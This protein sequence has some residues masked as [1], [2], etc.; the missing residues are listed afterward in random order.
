MSQI[1]ILGKI[2]VPQ[3]KA[4][5]LF[6]A[7]TLVTASI[8]LVLQKAYTIPHTD[9]ILLPKTG[10]RIGHN[11]PPTVFLTSFYR[12]GFSMVKVL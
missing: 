10:I 7:S 3:S 12:D 9:L 2:E 1:A 8:V 11:L 5:Y 6:N 4:S